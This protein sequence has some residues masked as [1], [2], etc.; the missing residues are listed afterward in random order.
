M[1][2]GEKMTCPNHY[3]PGPGRK[4]KK[5]CDNYGGMSRAYVRHTLY[6]GGQQFIPMGWWCG[7]CGKFVADK[8]KDIDARFYPTRKDD[9]KIPNE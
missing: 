9:E 2:R 4:P 3:R 5:R 7:S 1:A 6:P 8:K